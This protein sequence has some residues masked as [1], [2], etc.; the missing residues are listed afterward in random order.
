MQRQSFQAWVSGLPISKGGLGWGWAGE[1]SSVQLS[2]PDGATWPAHE[3]VVA[4]VHRGALLAALPG[5]PVLQGQGVAEG[6]QQ[7][8]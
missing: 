6:G 8:A 2:L 1:T 3:S 4:G 7:E 5:L